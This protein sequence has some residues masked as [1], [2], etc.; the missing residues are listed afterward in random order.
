MFQY[1]FFF[2][3]QWVICIKAFTDTR[4]C[5]I[6]TF[7]STL[8]PRLFHCGVF[9]LWSVPSYDSIECK[10][11]NRENVNKSSMD[12][13]NVHRMWEFLF[14]TWWQHIQ[15]THVQTQPIPWYHE[16]HCLFAVAAAHSNGEHAHQVALA[17]TSAFCYCMTFAKMFFSYNSVLSTPPSLAT[18]ASVCVFVCYVACVRAYVWQLRD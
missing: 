9:F 7:S 15:C 5:R 1:F 8:V 3:I 16:W 18:Y 6:E 14:D 4:L 17:S 10:I 13:K 2:L 12:G 11:L